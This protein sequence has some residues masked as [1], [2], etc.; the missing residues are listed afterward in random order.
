MKEYGIYIRCCGGKPYMLH[1]FDN[2]M[3]AKLKL[4]DMISTEEERGRPYFVDNDFFDNKYPCSVN[5]KYYCIQERE[6][7]EFVR[8]SEEK[9]VKKEKDK[10]VFFQE[11]K[12]NY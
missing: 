12:K 5:L 9:E 11:F 6:V 2:I 1:V 7:S 3:Q 10:I 8:Y 4:Y